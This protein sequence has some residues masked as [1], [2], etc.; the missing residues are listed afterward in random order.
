MNDL[1]RDY[2]IDLSRI[3][4]IGLY[5]VGVRVGLTRPFRRGL[6]TLYPDLLTGLIHGLSTE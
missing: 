2:P 1:R 3:G 6:R 4:W 5:N